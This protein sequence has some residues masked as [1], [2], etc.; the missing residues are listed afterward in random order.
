M[1]LGNQLDLSLGCAAMLCLLLFRVC[2]RAAV[3]VGSPWL[4]LGEQAGSVVQLTKDTHR[5]PQVLTATGGTQQVGCI[6]CIAV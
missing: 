1:Q 3:A 6:R 2:M 4:H 5:L